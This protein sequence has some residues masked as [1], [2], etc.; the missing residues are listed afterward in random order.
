[1]SGSRGRRDKEGQLLGSGRSLPATRVGLRLTSL[2]VNLVQTL[3]VPDDLVHKPKL[4]EYRSGQDE[5][6]SVLQ[7]HTAVQIVEHVG[8][9]EPAFDHLVERQ[10]P[11]P[12]SAISGFHSGSSDRLGCNERPHRSAVSSV[13]VTC[14]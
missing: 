1:M 14:R 4:I 9:R 11:L 13:S 7:P 2:S 10:G 5:R 6:I 12:K 8:Q 3:Q